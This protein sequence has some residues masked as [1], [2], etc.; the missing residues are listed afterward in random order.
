MAHLI[1]QSRG[2]NRAACFV[3]GEPAWHKLGKVVSEAQ[4]SEQAITLAELDWQV[5][6]REVYAPINTP[7]GRGYQQVPGQFAVTRS[8]TQAVLGVVG[9]W[10]KQA[11]FESALSLAS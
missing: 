3:A 7:D 11:A 10:F 5:E 9:A 6:K 2:E 4:T 1:D 8:D